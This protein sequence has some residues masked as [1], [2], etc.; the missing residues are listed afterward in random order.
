MG[1]NHGSDFCRNLALTTR[2]ACY[3]DKARSRHYAVINKELSGTEI[4]GFRVV[5]E[6]G[7]T[8]GIMPA[9]KWEVKP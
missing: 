4:A 1:A 3:L 8:V 6:H 7:P 9:F 5:V 2:S